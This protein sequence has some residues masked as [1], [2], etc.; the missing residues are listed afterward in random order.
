MASIASTARI[1]PHVQLGRNVTVGDCAIVGHP[2]ADMAGFQVKTIIG[3]N[4][5][6][7]S[8]SIIYAGSRIDN[9]FQT[10]HRAIIG[11]GMEIGRGCSIGTNSVVAGFCKLDHAARIH[12]LCCVE[13]FATI[14]ER[15]WVGPSA[16]IESRLDRITVVG[17]GAILAMRVHLLAG[18]RVGER[19]LIGTRSTIGNDVTPYRLVIGD[20]PRAVRTIDK[21]VSPIAE[22]GRP[23]QDDA[24]EVRD[25]NLARHAARD[26]CLLPANDWRVKLWHDLH[27]ARSDSHGPWLP[28]DRY[29]PID[30]RQ[31]IHAEMV[32]TE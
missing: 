3:D 24:P 9:N 22:I 1:Y 32:G 30:D 21:I 31:S 20:P 2:V 17:A 4:A 28:A 23:Y 5:V 8:H 15:A 25:A 26:G 29:A 16:M 13:P 11:P 10:G 18:V 12:S 7:R 27:G 6:I 14:C 19:A